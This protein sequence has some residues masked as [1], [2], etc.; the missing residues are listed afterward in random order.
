LICAALNKS[1]LVENSDEYIT[2]SKKFFNQNDIKFILTT[3]AKNGM[4][5]ESLFD[6]LCN[7]LYD[8]HIRLA[9]R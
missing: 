2:Y 5:V 4:N 3:S 8:V 7:A 6:Q 9:K 1:D